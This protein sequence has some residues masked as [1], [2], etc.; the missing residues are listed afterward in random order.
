MAERQ[1]QNAV[2]RTDLPQKQS[3]IDFDSKEIHL[4]HQKS[5]GSQ[6]KLEAIKQWSD[7]TNHWHTSNGSSHC[8][9]TIWQASSQ[10]TQH[11]KRSTSETKSERPQQR[12][13]LPDNS[14]ETLQSMSLMKTPGRWSTNKKLTA[15][16]DRTPHCCTDAVSTQTVDSIQHA[17]SETWSTSK[18]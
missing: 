1:K 11:W 5:D 14:D 16:K 15:S 4:R 12:A 10:N 18:F 2:Q 6:Q 13:L 9:L 3:L 7:T 17:T 8:K